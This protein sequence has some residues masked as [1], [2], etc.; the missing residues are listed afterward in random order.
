MRQCLSVL[1]FVANSTTNDA[2][3]FPNLLRYHK[4]KY[5]FDFTAHF[6]CSD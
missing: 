1:A 2:S 4:G 6:L 5:V 3:H